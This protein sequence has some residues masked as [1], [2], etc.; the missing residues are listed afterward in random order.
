LQWV[1]FGGSDSPFAGVTISQPQHIRGLIGKDEELD[2]GERVGAL[3]RSRAARQAAPRQT[4]D[5]MEGKPFS[6]RDR[7]QGELIRQRKL[8]TEKDRRLSLEKCI[9]YF[10]E[11]FYILF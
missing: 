2:C 4:T 10:S 1:C 8:Q 3:A 6:Y 11:T 5:A 9:F 7:L